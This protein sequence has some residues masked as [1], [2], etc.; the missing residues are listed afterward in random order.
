ISLF[1]NEGAVPIRRFIRFLE[2]LTPN[3][4][5]KRQINPAMQEAFGKSF[6]WIFWHDNAGWAVHPLKACEWL[7]KKSHRLPE[8]LKKFIHSAKPKKR[9]PLSAAELQKF[10]RQVNE[11]ERLPRAADN[12]Y[13]LAQERFPD[14]NVTRAAVR[15]I[16]GRLYPEQAHKRGP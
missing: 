2:A 15:G 13:R 7:A 8:R 12:L 11:C 6:A 9:H 1:L 16:A 4:I 10:I 3:N 14:C 5:Y